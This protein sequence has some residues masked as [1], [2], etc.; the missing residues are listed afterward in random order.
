MAVGE[1]EKVDFIYDKRK[2]NEGRLEGDFSVFYDALDKYLEKF[3]KAAE[4]R[5]NT[6]A[7]HMPLAVSVAQLI[8][9]V[10][11]LS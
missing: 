3:G 6:S 7:A 11:F 5:R 8:R 4:E 10:L 9:K 2:S 1:E